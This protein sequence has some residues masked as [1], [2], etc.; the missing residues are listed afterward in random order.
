MRK[1]RCEPLNDTH[2]IDWFNCGHGNSLGE[3]LSNHARI[4]SE[5]NQSRVWI[6]C[7]GQSTEAIGYF[8]LSSHMLI[9][10]T[11]SKSMRDGISPSTSHPAQLLGKF[12]VSA[13]YH[14]TE[15][16]GILMF[17]VFNVFAQVSNLTGARFLVLDAPE[18]KVRKF[19]AAFGFKA[20][21]NSRTMVMSADAVAN[22]LSAPD[23][24]L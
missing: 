24:R 19:Y 11:L 5:R 17:H 13:D 8:T 18:P 1:L 20:L 7:E 6:L 12:A 2:V 23:Q 4:F 10:D 22:S 16:S 9:G 15:V 14:G 3:W 21:N